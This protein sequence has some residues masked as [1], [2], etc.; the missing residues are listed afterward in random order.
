ML[1]TNINKFKAF[2]ILTAVFAVGSAACSGGFFETASGEPTNA[3]ESSFAKPIK[4]GRLV[5][6]ELTEASGIATSKC[7][8]N[9]YW[10]HNDSGDDAYIYAIDETGKN[11][12]VWK[13]DAA[14]NVDWED[15]ASVRDVSGNCSLFIGDIG[16]NEQ[17]REVLQIYKTAEPEITPNG[18]N[19]NR[20]DAIATELSQVL[21]FSYP[22]GP[23]NAEALL[24]LPDGKTAYIA[25]K[26][27]DGPSLIYKI[28]TEFGGSTVQAERVGE[29]AVPAVPN[30]LVTGGDI[31]PDARTIVL[32][33]YFGAY[34]LVLPADIKNFDEIWKQKPV[35]FD[36]GDRDVGEAIA[37]TSTG[38]A[39][40]AVSE[41]KH[42]PVYT[43]K[44][45]IAS[46][47]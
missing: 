29:V 39:V 10:T 32:C 42:T 2:V 37:F 24:V 4:T 18:V 5:S 22:D 38:S 46:S 1:K 33:D 17:K 14:T 13:V 36:I 41:N 44:R 27:K 12:G 21:S 30:G 31:S 47:Q 34:E 28:S 45:R 26:R 43:A 11:L 8:E 40:I 25:T 23:H 16:N 3:D 6:D 7:Q 9:V 35:R 20:N 15:I 19:M